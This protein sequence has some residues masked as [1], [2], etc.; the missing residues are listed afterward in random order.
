MLKEAAGALVGNWLHAHAQCWPVGLSSVHLDGFIGSRVRLNNLSSIPL[1]L[2][3]P[4]AEPFALLN[5]GLP[6][7][8][9]HL[10]FVQD[11]DTCKLFEAACY[12]YAADAD[13]NMLDRFELLLP[14]RART[15]LADG[16]ITANLGQ[17]AYQVG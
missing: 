8:P 16:R 1:G 12:A 4:V 13:S 10:R 5:R 15:L 11:S 7:Q 2:A 9:I 6:L 14:M 3:S 17:V